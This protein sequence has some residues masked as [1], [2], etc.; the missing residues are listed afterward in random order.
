MKSILKLSSLSRKL[1]GF[2]RKTNRKKRNSI[3]WWTRFMKKPISWSCV[4]KSMST[5]WSMS[6]SIRWNLL[7]CP[8][9][10]SRLEILI[11]EMLSWLGRL[12]SLLKPSLASNAISIKKTLQEPFPLSIATLPS[13]FRQ[14]ETRTRNFRLNSPNAMKS[15]VPCKGLLE[16]RKALFLLEVCSQIGRRKE[17][18]YCTALRMIGKC[19]C[20]RQDYCTIYK[21]TGKLTWLR[22]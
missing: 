9:K 18:F 7:K 12:I 8:P 14:R 16:N 17:N 10:S 11:R 2:K 6:K 19:M 20:I 4:N 1:N 22:E 15:S 13:S 5:T 21:E 3:C